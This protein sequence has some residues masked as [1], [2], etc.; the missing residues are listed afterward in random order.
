MIKAKY[1]ILI[2]VSETGEFIECCKIVDMPSMPSAGDKMEII[3]LKE[4]LSEWEMAYDSFEMRCVDYCDDGTIHITSFKDCPIKGGDLQEFLD[5]L[6]RLRYSIDRGD[7]NSKESFR[8]LA[9]AQ[10][11]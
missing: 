9:D 8:M 7:H 11:T 4:I 3:G 5:A 1:S 10:E 2:S 6:I